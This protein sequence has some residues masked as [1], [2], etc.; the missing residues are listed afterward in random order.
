MRWLESLDEV[1]APATLV[2]SILAETTGVQPTVIAATAERAGWWQRLRDA[3]VPVLRPALQ[4]RFA[5][6]F[7][8]AFFS[9][10]I[11]LNLAGVDIRGLHYS[12]LTPAALKDTA[13]RTYYETEARV[14]R[15]YENLRFVYEIESRVRELKNT[16]LPDEQAPVKKSNE[17]KG[18]ND[19]T[20][21]GDQDRK[22]QRQYSRELSDT[23]LAWLRNLD[24]PSAASTRSE[25]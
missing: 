15:Y 17:K 5:M 25:A 22:D 6:S 20:K 23:M 13:V 10:S 19:R 8:M 16:A 3:A 9:I 7:A 4:P 12:D 1:E 21:S 2:Q 24:L 11:V 18:Q 14:V